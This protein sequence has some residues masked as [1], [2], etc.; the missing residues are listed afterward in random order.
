MPTWRRRPL[1]VEWVAASS[2]TANDTWTQSGQ[3]LPVT[4]EECNAAY[5]IG[6]TRI[7]SMTLGSR[8]IDNLLV[9]LTVRESLSRRCH[10]R[11]RLSHAVRRDMLGGNHHWHAHSRTHLFVD[12][13]IRLFSDFESHRDRIR[14]GSL[15]PSSC[16]TAVHKDLEVVVIA[17]DGRSLTSEHLVIDGAS[18]CRVVVNIVSCRAECSTWLESWKLHPNCGAAILLVSSIDGAEP[19]DGSREADVLASM[20]QARRK[21]N[22]IP[23]ALLRLNVTPT[24]QARTLIGAE[25]NAFHIGDAESKQPRTPRSNLTSVHPEGNEYSCDFWRVARPSSS[26]GEQRLE[27]HALMP[28]T[29]RWPSW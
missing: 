3:H 5:R 11:G 4:S 22:A 10:G 27:Q 20:A 14:Y 15:K 1:A 6:C 12:G 8:V 25:R 24:D 17:K 2:I 13:N 16:R 21:R 7:E 18:A 29:H 19:P 26:V 23:V 28:S 9:R